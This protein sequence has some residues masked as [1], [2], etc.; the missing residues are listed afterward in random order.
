MEQQIFTYTQP[1]EIKISVSE[2]MSAKGTSQ[3]EIDITITRKLEHKDEV[4]KI[5]EADINHAIEKVKSTIKALKEL[6]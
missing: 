5:I 4:Y 6:D 2:K 1:I 3:P